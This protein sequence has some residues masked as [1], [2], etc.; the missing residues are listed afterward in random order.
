MLRE[1]RL[2]TKI[3]GDDR[4]RV[5][6]GSPGTSG[7]ERP[8]VCQARQLVSRSLAYDFLMPEC[9]R[10]RQLNGVA[11]GDEA[12]EHVRGDRLTSTADR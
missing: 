7:E 3:G 10:E 6:A 11:E 4:E 12:A 8:T 5:V 2:N 9:I 1:G